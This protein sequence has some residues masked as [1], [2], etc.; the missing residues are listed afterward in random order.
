VCLYLFINQ[1]ILFIYLFKTIIIGRLHK[2][3][4]KKVRSA[5][6]KKCTAFVLETF[7]AIFH[8]WVIARVILGGYG[9]W[10][11]RNRNLRGIPTKMNDAAAGLEAHSKVIWHRKWTKKQ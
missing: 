2:H 9:K 3:P 1:I 10:P 6:D 8:E 5:Y 4:A 7:D 11:S